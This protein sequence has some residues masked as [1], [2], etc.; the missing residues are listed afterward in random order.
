V[1]KCAD[2]SGKDAVSPGLGANNTGNS[3]HYGA[4]DALLRTAQGWGG[5]KA[6]TLLP[7][8]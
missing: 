2:H 1:G 6:A 4:L 3:A 5:A 8:P 7:L